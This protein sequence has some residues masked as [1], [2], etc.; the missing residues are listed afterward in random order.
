MSQFINTDNF[1]KLRLLSGTGA[2]A[3]VRSFVLQGAQLFVA[4]DEEKIEVPGAETMEAFVLPGTEDQ[5]I[6]TAGMTILHPWVVRTVS[7]G[8]SKATFGE[9]FI[10]LG[11]SSTKRI[12]SQ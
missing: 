3:Q 12:V 10:S 9:F 1:L 11:T 6:T 7:H 4:V 5:Y 2:K 8:I